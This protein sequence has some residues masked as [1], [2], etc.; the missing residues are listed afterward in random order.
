MIS[1]QWP[2]A[3]MRRA[4]SDRSAQRRRRRRRC[5]AMSRLL[6]ARRDCRKFPAR[7]SL[8][9][10]SLLALHTLCA[11]PWHWQAHGYRIVPID[12]RHERI[13]GEAVPSLARCPPRIACGPDRHDRRVPP[14]RGRDADRRPGDRDR[15]AG[16]V[17][18][19][20]CRR[21]AGRRAG[22]CAGAWPPGL[23]YT[24]RLSMEPACPAALVWAAPVSRSA[25]CRPRFV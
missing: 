15:C 14:Y 1:S 13:L 8:A 21:C 23:F 18:A 7:P 10:S 3:C 11:R 2:T 17:A 9:R 6:H 4:P 5:R 19:T 24:R 22:P 25:R 20:G 12:P 16:A